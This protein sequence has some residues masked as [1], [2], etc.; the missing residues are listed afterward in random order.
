MFHGR[1]TNQ[2]NLCPTKHKNSPISRHFSMGTVPINILLT[3]GAMF[4]II[5]WTLS[6]PYG[7]WNDTTTP[8]N[9]ALPQ[10]LVQFR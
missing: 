6:N 1:H 9:I 8:Q 4:S 10:T 5:G 3:G 7:M 2:I